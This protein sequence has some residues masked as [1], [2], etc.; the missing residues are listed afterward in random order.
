MKQILLFLDLYISFFT[1][2]ELICQTN[3]VI[4]EPVLVHD[5]SVAFGPGSGFT[6]FLKMKMILSAL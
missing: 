4:V 5:E 1:G 6:W 3:N 2:S